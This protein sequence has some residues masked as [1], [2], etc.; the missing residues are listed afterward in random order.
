[1]FHEPSPGRPARPL[2]WQSPYLAAASGG[3]ERG[4]GGSAVGLGCPALVVD[5]LLLRFALFCLCKVGQSSPGFNRKC[6]VL[7]REWLKATDAFL[8]LSICFGASSRVGAVFGQFACGAVVLGTVLVF[9]TL[10]GAAACACDPCFQQDTCTA[11][12]LVA[13]LVL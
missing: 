9:R 11:Q 6:F 4:A 1:M 5:C 2:P 10:H 12:V 3:S 13:A 8:F 7:M